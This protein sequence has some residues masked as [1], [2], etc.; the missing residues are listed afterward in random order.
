MLTLFQ[1]SDLHFGSPH[2]PVAAAALARAIEDAE[3]DVLVLAG[4]FTQRAKVREYEQARAFLDA[5]PDVPTVVTPGN[6]DVPLYRVA[7]RLLHPLRNYR[8]YISEALDTV[9]EVPG[10]MF[11]ALDSTAPHRAIV[12][13]RVDGAQLAFAARNFQRADPE[14]LRVVVLHHHL[15]GAPDYERDSPLPGARRLLDRMR[16]MGVELV[17]GGHLHRGFVAR[18]ADVCPDHRNGGEV[19]IAHSGTACST[20]GRAREKGRMSVNLI[21]VEDERIVVEQ[22]LLDDARERYRPTWTYVWPRA[23]GPAA[24]RRGARRSSAVEEPA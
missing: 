16:E 21:R 8:R 20:R 14:A 2:D 10:A 18:S 23:L 15:A 3:P 17:L 7:E 13:G 22:R 24:G 1:A 12:N 19:L 4:D 9:T 5:L 6:H 11:V